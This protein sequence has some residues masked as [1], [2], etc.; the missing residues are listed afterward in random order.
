MEIKKQLINKLREWIKKTNVIEVDEDLNSAKLNWENGYSFE[1]KRLEEIRGKTKKE[2]YIISFKTK[3]VVT[4]DEKGEIDIFIE[5]M[6][7]WAYFDAK[8]LDLM[9][10][11]KK[12]GYIEV[13][14]SF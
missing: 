4:Y 5:G 14:G 10:I 9:Y 11:H 13:D 8:T 3:D 1:D 12:T 2:V 6:Y 7:C